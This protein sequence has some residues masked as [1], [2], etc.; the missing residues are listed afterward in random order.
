MTIPDLVLKQ[1]RTIVV[2]EGKFLD[3]EELKTLGIGK[4]LSFADL[5]MEQGNAEFEGDNQLEGLN[6]VVAE[7]SSGEVEGDD[8][9]VDQNLADND[10]TAE[11]TTTTNGVE[12]N[13]GDDTSM[14]VDQPENFTRRSNR[15]GRQNLS[16]AEEDVE[17][18]PRFGRRS[19]VDQYD[20]EWSRVSS[21]D[22][23]A[24]LTTI[25]DKIEECN[26]SSA[27]DILRPAREAQ[28]LQVMMSQLTLNKDVGES[29]SSLRETSNQVTPIY[30]HEAS[31]DPG[32]RE[33]MRQEY[34]SLIDNA[35]WELTD[36]PP[37]R[38]VVKTKWVYKVKSD[39]R[40]KSR[41]V[42]KGF[43]Q[44][45][46]V[47]FDETWSPVGRKSSLKMLISHVQ[48][49]NWSW[50][51]MD[52][53]TAFLNSKL[54]EE[55]Y[56]DQ[57][58]GFD[59]GTG[60]VCRLS[61]AIYGLKQASRAWY[62]TL[63]IF[64]TSQKLERS[65]VDPCIY[66]GKGTILFVYVDDLI[67]AAESPQLVENLAQ[68]FKNHFRM[69]DLGKPKKILGID[70]TESPQGVLFSG[71][72]IIQDLLQRYQMH[73]SRS[74]STPLDPNQVF[75]PRAEGKSTPEEQSLFASVI[76]SLL[77]LANSYRP[78][79]SYAVSM[80]SQFTSNP[81]DDH[82][83]GVKRILRYLNGTK[84]H[85][86]FFPK[87]DREPAVLQGFTDADYAACFTRKSRTGYAFFVGSSLVSWG[88]RKQSVI[89]LSTC[90]AEYYAL[91]EGAKEAIHLKRLLWEIQHQI[92][93]PDDV[94]LDA[95]TL[96]CDNQ[97]TI[98]VS[99]NPAEHRMMKHVDLRYKWI[100][101]KVGEGEFKIEYVRTQD[102][103]ADLFTKSLAKNQHEYLTHKCN[104]LNK[105]MQLEREC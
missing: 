67:I 87:W 64:L 54:D 48:R 105:T 20:E 57:P 8:A 22:E 19:L 23:L 13:N 77:Y 40:W 88:S 83:K 58:Q 62:N 59:D 3:Q 10:D 38:K 75:L 44:V 89:A 68:E 104:V 35:T 16:Y 6:Q 65:R 99:K 24:L 34:Q 21:E 74:V 94:K 26:L 14:D 91:T 7:P 53:D 51:Q 15:H 60:K 95:V 49:N 72:D 56:M 92:P 96:F 2:D 79:I 42:A 61:K 5:Q 37:G 69:K 85:G 31:Q 84:D 36:L 46:G 12:V 103:C 86:L 63:H 30:F 71:S 82:W 32:W 11:E 102:Q 81:S 43:T 80:L 39:G 55:I 50:K 41:L 97:S 93:L 70:L 1:V 45:A 9:T 90:E 27:E 101:E 25:F 47:D 100:Q 66:F 17:W 78:D 98:F 33:S 76:G 18:D 73:G 29:Q 4:S 52:V 28:L